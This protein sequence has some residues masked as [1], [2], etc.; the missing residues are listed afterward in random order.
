MIKRLLWGTALVLGIALAG[1][2][3]AMQVPAADV[4]AEVRT[5]IADAGTARVIVGVRTAF[6][7]EGLLAG[8][9]AVADQ[10]A[11]MQAAMAAVIGQAAAAGAV[12]GQPFETIPFFTA[13]VDAAALAALAALPNVFSIAHDALERATLAQSTPLINAPAAWSA[14]ATGAGWNVAILDTGV[15]KTHSFFGGRVVSEACY[16]NAGGG[17]TSQGGSTLCPGGVNSSTAAGSG[18]ACT[19]S[20]DGCFHGTHVAGI[21]A[22]ANAPGGTNGV[23][24]GAG[25]I[26]IQVFTRVDNSGLCGSSAPCVLSYVSDQILALER[27]LALAGPG[28]ANRIASANMSLGGGGFIANCDVAQAA[29]K[30]AIDNL[31]SIGVATV[32]ATGNN[33]YIDGVSAPACIS[34]AVAV[35]STTKA[36]VMSSFSNRR[37]G[38]VDVVAPG[39][40]I[41]SSVLGNTYG[42]ASGTS[43]ATPHVA[44]AWAVLKQAV[45]SASVA[46]IQTALQNTGQVINDP[47]SGASYR[48]INV[49]AARLQLVAPGTIPGAPGTP[50]VSGGGNNIVF[51]WTAPASGGT[52]TSYTLIARGG[53]GGPVLTQVNVG[54]TLSIGVP[55]PN[56]SF[57]VTVQASNA[58]GN[59][60]E[61]AGVSFSVPLVPPA[62]GAP[63]GLTATVNGAQVGFTWTAPASGGTPTNYVLRASASPGGAPIVTL[64]VPA[65][66]TAFAVAAPAGTYYVRIAAANAGGTGPLSNEVTVVVAPPGPPTMNAPTVT[67]T[68]VGLSWTA[69]TTGGTGVTSYVVVASMTPGGAPVA[70]LPTT[71]LGINVNAPRGTFYVRV[72][73][74]NAV[75]QGT[76][77]NEVTVVVP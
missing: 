66:P 64:P 51:T 4:P 57:Y 36:D 75:G 42:S 1:Q 21:A 32:I 14:G 8:P 11:A 53:P 56:G 60:P 40:S 55:A 7:P 58:S 17:A 15:E 45:P 54:N 28:N 9:A 68:T 35:G 37:D 52:P 26:A 3:P 25:I 29:R 5:A 72:H 44:G 48:R 30:A 38:L 6:V 24:P 31:L 77:S 50:V 34:T 71:G 46:Q 39:S 41:T 63:T 33:G 65:S 62:P 49:N 23:A 10:R 73:A 20:L 47:P 27:V 59:G 70:Q 22:G 69:P 67:G 2:R 76:A 18:A 74:R 12:V 43:M 13:E 16:S 61:S 19:A